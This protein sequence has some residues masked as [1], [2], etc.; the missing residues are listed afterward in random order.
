MRGR[1]RAPTAV[2]L[3][4]WRHTV[5]DVRPLD[6]ERA[7]PPAATLPTPPPAPD[8]AP[9]AR[10]GPPAARAAAAPP[11]PPPS[12]SADRR[13][14]HKLQRGHWPVAARLDLHGL[15]QAEAHARLVGFIDAQHAKG[16]RCVLVI[17][18]RGLR[19]G[20]ILRAETPR[21]LA[22]GALAGKV[23]AWT[24]ARPGQG[25]EGAL[26]VLLRRQRQD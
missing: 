8:P 26:Y 11:A 10:P 20:G 6:P 24:A 12:L 14:L 5:H 23:L 25:G 7:E 17:T 18:G 3:A 22:S 15:T 1:A 2:E 4:L 9:A 13:L 21:W 19:S 16:A